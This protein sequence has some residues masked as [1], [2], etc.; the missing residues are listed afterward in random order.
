M[1]EWF[2]V[3]VFSGDKLPASA[4][5]YSYEDT[6]TEAAVTSGALYWDWRD[7]E[8]GVVFEILFATDEQW[9]AFRALPAVRGAL[10]A[11]PDP[12]NG[13]LIYRGRGGAAGSRKPRSPK[14]APGAAALE[15]DEPRESRR[16]RLTK[17][18]RAILVD[19]SLPVLDE[20]GDPVRQESARQ[21]AAWLRDNTAR[22]GAAG[23]TRQLLV[24]SIIFLRVYPGN[25]HC[26]WRVAASRVR[27]GRAR[28]EP[29]ARGPARRCLVNGGGCTELGGL[30]G[31]RVTRRKHNPI[32]RKHPPQVR[33]PGI[34]YMPRENTA[35]GGEPSHW[36]VQDGPMTETRV[37]TEDLRAA[38]EH[39]GY[40]PGLVI[41]AVASAL[42][43]EPVTAFFVQ[44]D[45]IFDPG[46]EVR[47]H[48]TVL[49]LTPTRLVYSHT[50][51]H[52]ADEA[53]S[54]P[55]AETS[56]EAVRFGRVSSMSLTRVVPDP[57]SYVPGVTM[58]SE[59]ILTIGWNVLSHV[60]LEP[61]HCGDETCEAD[62]GYLGTITAD[63]LTLRISEAADGMDAIRQ[64][65]AFSAALSDA[66]A[67]AAA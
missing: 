22:G 10:D 61:A 28:G 65:L 64:V 13:L 16:F 56:T 11:V 66:T 42:G 48:M 54:L 38:I 43:P 30:G 47:R 27:P 39:A 45:A 52:P 2:S 50:D 3:E 60:E 67:R 57:A 55:R 26:Y 25:G 17:A 41:D 31:R 9:E 62:H 24:S 32:C 4:W 34:G 7:S 33:G 14:P 46:M 29:G 49:A 53:E 15:L 12:V 18:E 1:A 23:A 5:R 36:T 40:Y 58:P 35:S 21:E 8:Y 63:D 37:R 59:V 20:P 51:E 44:H 6:L 19:E